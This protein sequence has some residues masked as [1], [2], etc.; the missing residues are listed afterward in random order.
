MS[1]IK[2][3]HLSSGYVHIRGNGPCNWAQ[4]PFW[5][6]SAEELELGMFP[7]AGETFRQEVEDARYRDESEEFEVV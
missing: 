6:C 5:P 3:E 1:Q 4:V 2:F 7:E